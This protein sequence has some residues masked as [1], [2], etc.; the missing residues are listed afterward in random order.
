M[1]K[2]P[3]GGRQGHAA[4]QKPA[5]IKHQMCVPVLLVDATTSLLEAMSR[6]PGDIIGAHSTLLKLGAFTDTV[7]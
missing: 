4:K 5:P 6:M 1:A 7:R 2:A 3:G